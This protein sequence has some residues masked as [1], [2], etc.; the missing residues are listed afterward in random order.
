M[1]KVYIVG[2]SI[3]MYYGPY[4]ERYLSGFA[5]YS[6]KEADDE[7][8]RRLGLPANANGCNS[9]ITLTFLRAKVASGTLDADMVL[10]NCGLH[11]IR[12]K[13]D[14]GKIEV[15]VERYRSNLSEIIAL[16]REAK[17]ELVW[18]RTTPCDENVHNTRPN[19]AFHRFA[20]DCN[21]YNEAADAIMA[22]AGV[23]IIDLHTFTSNLGDDL[24]CDHVH[25]KEHVREKQAAFIA[26]WL[27]GR[28]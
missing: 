22:E 10:L 11:D 8:L 12:R 1:K 9:D 2:D 25:F 18:I 4:L 14:T 27:A 23:P 3:S 19:I 5:I 16:V 21:A 24:Y 28:L 13:A 26:G 7:A 6:R 20:A 17:R 15:P